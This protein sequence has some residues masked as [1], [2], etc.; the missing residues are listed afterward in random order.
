[1]SRAVP[2]CT[3]E[4]SV[5][6]GRAAHIAL[7]ICVVNASV[8]VIQQFARVS[9]HFANQLLPTLHS[10]AAVCCGTRLIEINRMLVMRQG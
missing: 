3:L 7:Y 10:R 2:F 4:A 6:S 9:G 5:G 8:E 1:M